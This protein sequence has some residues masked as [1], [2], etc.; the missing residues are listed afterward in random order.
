MSLNKSCVTPDSNNIP[1]ERER[2]SERE[3]YIYTTPPQ[4]TFLCFKENTPW[5]LPKSTLRNE[6][7]ELRLRFGIK[8][9][10]YLP[11]FPD[12]GQG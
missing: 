3:I 5:F 6:N 10:I 4:V 12:W 2:E 1:R 9:L 8:S 7:W 11:L